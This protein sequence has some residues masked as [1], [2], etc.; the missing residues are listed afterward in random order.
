MPN[1]TSL[2]LKRDISAGL[3]QLCR[4][5]KE[6]LDIEKIK[7]EARRLWERRGS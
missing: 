2:D 6:P 5:E 3:D 7:A 1:K 4:G